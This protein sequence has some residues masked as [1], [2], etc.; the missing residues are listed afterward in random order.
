MLMIVHF[1]HLM[2]VGHSEGGVEYRE[3]RCA[4]Q[5][6]KPEASDTG[7]M[8]SPPTATAQ[9]DLPGVAQLGRPTVR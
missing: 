1:V 4:A 6:D 2:I 8:R 3:I 5:E 7:A 9:K